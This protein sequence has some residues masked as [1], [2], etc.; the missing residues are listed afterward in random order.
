MKQKLYPKTSRVKPSKFKLSE[1]LD[2]S[3]IGFFN[4]DDELIIAQRRNVY[5]MTEVLNSP[6]KDDFYKGLREFLF[7]H[8]KELLESLYEGSGFFA[9]WIGMGKLK[10]DFKNRVHMF[11]KANIKFLINSEYDVYNIYYE[12]DLFVYPFKNQEIPKFISIV[13]SVICNAEEISIE[14]LDR[15][16]KIYSKDVQR[17]VEG[18]IVIYNKTSIRKYVRMKSGKLEDHFW[19]T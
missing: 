11:A 3:N 5:T 6:N 18:F 7:E 16:Y 15:L 8:G 12:P 4:C 1:K 17:D 2:G 9:E 13:P 14:Y 10:Y 19:R